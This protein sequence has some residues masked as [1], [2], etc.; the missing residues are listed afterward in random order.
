M[1]LGID[2]KTVEPSQIYQ[3][4]VEFSSGLQGKAPG[5]EARVAEQAWIPRC[6]DLGTTNPATLRVSLGLASCR[7]R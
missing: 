2:H 6:W 5:S 1:P 4:S 7:L 3:K